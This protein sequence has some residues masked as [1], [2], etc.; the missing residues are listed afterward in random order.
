MAVTNEHVKY[1]DHL[2]LFL[3]RLSVGLT[4]I[5]FFFYIGLI[6]IKLGESVTWAM[7]NLF[8]SQAD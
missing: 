3:P 4:Y 6:Y 8:D 7:K 2:G 1:V 5:F